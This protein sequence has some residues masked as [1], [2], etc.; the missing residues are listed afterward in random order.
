MYTYAKKLDH[1]VRPRCRS[2]LV[3][4][5]T[6]SK[7]YKLRVGQSQAHQLRI[8][9]DDLLCRSGCQCGSRE[10]SPIEF[11]HFHRHRIEL[12]RSW[13][14][15]EWG[16]RWPLEA[17]DRRQQLIEVRLDS[18]V[19][20]QTWVRVIFGLGHTWD[21]LGPMFLF[22]FG[23]LRHPVE[24]GAINIDQVDGNWKQHFLCSSQAAV[25]SWEYWEYKTNA[26]YVTYSFSSLDIESG[27]HAIRPRCVIRLRHWQ[28][29]FRAMGGEL[30][31]L[32]CLELRKLAKFTGLGLRKVHSS[33]HILAWN[34][35]PHP[36][37]MAFSTSLEIVWCWMLDDAGWCW[38]VWSTL[39]SQRWIWPGF[40]GSDDEWSL[41]R[42]QHKTPQWLGTV[43]M[44]LLVLLVWQLGM[45]LICF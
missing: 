42:A 1:I 41:P 11:H 20:E 23:R 3:L 19:A 17:S 30:E 16:L 4:H 9:A 38:C 7:R 34:L 5:F 2:H 39:K 29:A 24:L 35:W 21:I 36:A 8:R 28:D 6:W 10:N 25:V 32:G 18:R 22:A 15:S 43:Q 40:D 33:A 44:Q 45:P 14:E 37:N 27:C 13:G 31:R 12:H 26:T